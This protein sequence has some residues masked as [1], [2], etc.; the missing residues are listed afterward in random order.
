[1]AQ[2]NP[3]HVSLTTPLAETTSNISF[4]EGGSDPKIVQSLGNLLLIEKSINRSILNGC[5]SGKISAYA[6]SK[7]LLT[8]C[9]ANTD[10][11][12]VGT[13]D[14]ITTTVKTLKCWPIWTADAV[15][16]RQLFLTQ[17]AMSVWDVPKS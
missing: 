16:E 2:A 3:V 4:G 9:Q 10:A 6:Q 17:L 12:I 8:K 7:F 11:Q 1:M 14:K 5:Y 15:R 13:A